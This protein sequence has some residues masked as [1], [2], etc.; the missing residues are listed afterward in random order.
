METN[1]VMWVINSKFPLQTEGLQAV[2]YTEVITALF[3]TGILD[4]K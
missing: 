3:S 4:K 2:L 1:E